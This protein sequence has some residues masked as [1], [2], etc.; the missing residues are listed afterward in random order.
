VYFSSQAFLGQLEL[1]PNLHNEHIHSSLVHKHG[2]TSPSWILFFDSS[3][4][5]ATAFLS[6]FCNNRKD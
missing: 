3:G 4:W 2:K 6:S 5:F 1:D